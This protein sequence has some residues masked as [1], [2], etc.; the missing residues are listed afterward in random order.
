M[1]LTY[2]K[3]LVAV[4]GSQEAD[5]AFKKAL[6]ISKRNDSQIVLAHVIDTRNFPTIEAYDL[7]IRDRTESFAGEL[8]DKYKAEAAE[9]G[10]ED[11]KVEIELGNPKVKIAKDLPKKHETDLII[12]GATGL[13]A[14]ERLMLGSVSDYVTRHAACDVLVIRSEK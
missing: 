14:I 12:C 8:M 11:L 4:D 3:I 7:T 6:E 5:R 13:N 10:L 2:K 9:A 1:T